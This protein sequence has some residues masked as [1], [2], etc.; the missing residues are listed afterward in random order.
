MYDSEYQLHR[1]D[2]DDYSDAQRPVLQQHCRGTAE[3]HASSGSLLRDNLP[4]ASLTGGFAASD[5]AI[6]G[7]GA[8]AVQPQAQRGRSDSIIDRAEDTIVNTVDAVKW[9]ASFISNYTIF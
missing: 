3:Y 4:R 6:N 7:G 9:C 2:F 1:D 8:G 5:R